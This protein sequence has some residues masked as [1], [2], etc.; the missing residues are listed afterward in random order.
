[1]PRAAAARAAGRGDGQNLDFDALVQ[2]RWVRGIWKALGRQVTSIDVV[3]EGDDFLYLDLNTES[4]PEP[5]FHHYDFVTNC[6]TTEHVA[7]QYNSF[8][9]VHDLTRPGGFMYHSLPCCG[10]TSHGFFSYNAKF[11]Q[12][13]ALANGYVFHDAFITADPALR[14]LDEE[15]R[16]LMRQDKEFLKETPHGQP[17]HLIRDFQ[18]TDAGI[19]VCLQKP[20]SSEPFKPPLDI[21]AD[22]VDVYGGRVG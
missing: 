20:Q 2:E 7:N 14:P 3:G 8:K 4:V 17:D 18:T 12:L 22:D 6:G 19:R 5:H 9:V 16:K 10:M 11:F 1:M 13:L 15:S 21:R